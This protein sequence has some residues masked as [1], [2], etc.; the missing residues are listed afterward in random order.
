MFCV[1]LVPLF[2]SI[3]PSSVFHIVY[4]STSIRLDAKRGLQSGIMEIDR[5][6]AGG[7][8]R[9]VVSQ[10]AVETTRDRSNARGEH[11]MFSNL[12]M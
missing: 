7:T 12:Q 4:V 6:S 1:C 11:A 9:Q 10:L 5:Q 2:L 8:Q 3:C